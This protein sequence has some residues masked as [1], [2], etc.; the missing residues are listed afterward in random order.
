LCFPQIINSFF[1][2]EYPQLQK[3]INKNALNFIRDERA[4]VK[5]VTP[6]LGEFLPTLTVADAIEWKDI[7][8]PYLQ[9]NFD[10]NALWTI[11]KHP[12]LARVD[13]VERVEVARM[14]KTWDATKVSM[15][16]L[17]FH[18]YFFTKIARPAGV[19][20]DSVASNYDAFCGRPSSAMKEALQAKCKEILSA[21][22]WPDFFRAIGMPVPTP[23]YLTNWLKQAVQNSARKGYHR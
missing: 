1:I 18:V 2:K 16:L 8:I 9:E 17:M 19:G 5:D 20:L 13:S 14:D 10:R 11:K 22:S 3:E 7:Q 12:Q 21:N 6:N 23:I 15:R 4:R